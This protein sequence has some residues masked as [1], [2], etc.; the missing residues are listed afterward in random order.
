MSADSGTPRANPRVP[1][2]GNGRLRDYPLLEAVIESSA[3][4]LCVCHE[5]SEA[6]FVAFTVWN[7]RMK[8]ITGYTMDE[9]NRLGWYQTMFVDE[10]ESRRCARRMESMRTGEDLQQEEWRIVR[11]DGKLRD[12]IV[13]SSVVRAPDG[14]AHVMAVMSDF[15]ERKRAERISMRRAAILDAVSFSATTF[16]T[17]L[18]NQ[19]N[20]QQMLERL[21]GVT[22]AS[23]AYIFENA[24]GPDGE[25]LSSQRFEWCRLGIVP[26]INN[27][28]LQDLPLA[29]AGY[30]RWI[31]QLGERGLI[32]GKIQ[33]FP[34]PERALLESQAILSLAVAPIFVDGAWWGL[35]GFDDCRHGRRWSGAELLALQTAADILGAGLQR[36][37]IQGE[38]ERVNEELKKATSRA[39]NK[40]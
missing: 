14:A 36:Q 19:R 22:S 27:P 12:L 18:P 24:T 31:H 38:L 25:V 30:Q 1:P 8:R 21:G 13:S 23:R 37:R 4:G 33:D 34:E 26:Q 15:S 16:L 10:E 7:P 29:A 17:S 40:N 6:P 35:I 3:E 20:I 2:V 32:A 39:N 11:K 28:E 9:I 5:T